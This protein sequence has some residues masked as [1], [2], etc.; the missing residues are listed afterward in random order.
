MIFGYHWAI[1]LTMLLG[2]L[3]VANGIVNVTGPKAMRDNYQRWGFP[4]GWHLVNGAVCLITG[5]LLLIPSL[6]PF[7]FLLAALECFAIYATLIWN[8]DKSHLPPSIILL[9][10]LVVAYWGL[11]GFAPPPLGPF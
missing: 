11:Y 6:Q 10:L 1:L 7:G 8:K 2:I 5:V 4:R 9:I 3:F